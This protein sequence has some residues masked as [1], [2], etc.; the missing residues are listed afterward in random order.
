MFSFKDRKHLLKKIKIVGKLYTSLSSWVT[1]IV[2]NI[3]TIYS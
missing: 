1:E 2:Y 3:T